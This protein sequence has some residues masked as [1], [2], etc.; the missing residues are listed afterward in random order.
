M[1]NSKKTRLF[2]LVDNGTKKSSE[3]KT[4]S[5]FI[6][7]GLENAAKTTSLG[8]GAVKYTTTNNDFVD[9]FGKLS[10]FL[11]KREYAEVD[12]DMQLLFSQNKSK[13][14]KFMLYTRLVTR[15]VQL[16]NGEKTETSQR[17]Q[18]LKHEGIFRMIWL[19]VNQ[20]E[21]FKQNLALFISAGSWKDVITML[22]YDLEY[23]G[24]EGRKL[25]WDFL[26]KVILGGL[27]NPNTSELVK[28][29]LPQIKANGK[30]K[31]IEAQADNIIAKWVCSILFGGKDGDYSKYK[32]YRKL[33]SSG[34]AH[35]W[36][37]LIS[38]NQLLSLDFNSIAG[39]A[40]AQL[41]SSKF[42][43]N[44]KLTDVYESWIASQP[45][46]KY[47]GFVYEL[48]QPVKSGYINSQLKNHQKMTINAQFFGLL[49]KGRN[50]MLEGDNGL[51]VVVD[52]SSS[53]TSAVPGLKIS[54]YDVAKS[55]ALYFS[56]LLKG[57]FEGSWM[58]FNGTAQLKKWV[59][60][61]PVDK[62]QND[63]SEAYGDTNFQGV[64][65][66]F[67][68]IKVKGV[69]ESEFPSGILVVSD[70]CFNDSS[71][72]KSE[73][74][75]LKAKLLSY[76]FSKGYVDNFKIIIWDIP[77]SFYGGSSQTAFEGFDDVPNLFY[78]SGFDG[79]GIAFLTGV[80][81]PKN[82]ETPETNDTP[83]NAAELFEAAMD[84]ELLN[85]VKV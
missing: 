12:K 25:D 3:S 44:N 1:F 81:K 49:E 2:P 15:V 19:G 9:Q 82:S 57:R 41:V 71:K 4:T 6:N 8:N 27:E 74:Q 22:S 34:T 56:Y 45:T 77:N 28:K 50:G 46:A 52:S 35:K 43:D 72:Q 73:S 7:V 79:A 51:L 36:Q 42:L 62:L 75:I 66:A 29:Y 68:N 32:S 80:E 24:W 58:E 18:G 47:T 61:T 5:A 37:Q 17:G 83:K 21:L 26:G 55:M 10:N 84:Q 48:F 16:P 70:G 76:G 39:R 14:I 69:A 23:N 59:G 78:M 85:L 31:T 38:Q 65:T 63:K 67:E 33:K 53:M 40:L 64:A 60:N 54:S 20:P 11:K 30:C 13:A